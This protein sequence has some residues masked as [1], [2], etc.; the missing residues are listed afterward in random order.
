M[1]IF[2]TSL[3]NFVLLVSLYYLIK[4]TPNSFSLALDTYGDP[5]TWDHLVF[6]V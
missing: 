4:E 1:K 5:N 3:L 6:L 2:T